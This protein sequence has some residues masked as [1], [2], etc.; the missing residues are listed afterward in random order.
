[1]PLRYMLNPPTVPEREELME[2]D[3]A[4]VRRPK[5]NHL[6]RVITRVGFGQRCVRY[7]SFAGAFGNI[8]CY[9]G[10]L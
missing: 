2:M 10:E 9:N 3:R 4:K 1:M 6:R 5:Q 8:R 7:A